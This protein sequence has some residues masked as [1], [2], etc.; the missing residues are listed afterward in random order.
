MKNEIKN[1]SKYICRF[2]LD[3]N[4]LKIS[5]INFAVTY[6]CNSRCKMCNIWEIYRNEKSKI[7]QELTLK[8]IKFAFKDLDANLRSIT[9]TGGE[10]FLRDDLKKI[11]HFFHKK[12]HS[13]KITIITNGILKDKILDFA[14]RLKKIHYMI[15]IDGYDKES[16]KKVRGVDKFDEVVDLYNQLKLMG[17]DVGISSTISNYNYEEFWQIFKFLNKMGGGVMCLESYSAIYYHNKEVKIN[18]DILINNFN[19]LSKIYLKNRDLLNWFFYGKMI[20]YLK[21]NKKMIL[22]CYALQKSIFID[23]YGNVFPCIFI[24]NAIGNLKTESLQNILSSNKRF[25]IIRIIQKRKCP[26]C[27]TQCQSILNIK[28][29]LWK[30][31]LEAIKLLYKQ[32]V[33]M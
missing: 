32:L 29:N 2:L 26:N 31:P 23:P 21:N 10:P 16:Y 13:A 18:K 7:N 27:W 9:I 28:E 22:P 5:E 24:G 15:S 17:I 14:T 6:K 20:D 25:K 8:E 19:S 1:Y 12:F 11:L 33:R 3:R 4:F 30:M